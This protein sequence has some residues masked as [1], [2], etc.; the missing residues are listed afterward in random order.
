MTSQISIRKLLK[1]EL[2]Q[3]S[4]MLGLTGLMHLLTGPV[5]F[6]LGTSN[7][8]N[9]S[10]S[11]AV[12][13]YHRFFT[14]SFFIWQLFTMLGCLGVGIFIYRYLFSRR[15]V[16]LY[17]SVPISRSRLFL[18]KYLHGLLIWFLPFAISCGSIFLFYVIRSAGESFFWSGLYAFAKTFLLL[19]LCYFIFYHLFLTAVYLSGNVLNMFTNMAIMGSSVI[20]IGAAIYALADG[21]FDTFC[22]EP[23]TLLE[24]ILLCLSP[25][26]TPF[27]I[28]GFMQ[29]GALNRHVPLLIIS[30]IISL[31]LLDA[32]WILCMKRP[33]ELAER[34]TESP[35]YIMLA[36][37][38][39]TILVGIA[40]ALFFSSISTNDGKLAWGIFGAALG[41][42][43]TFG[44]LNSIYKTT[45]KGFFK[46]PTQL[47]AS[48]AFSILLIVSFQLDWFGYNAYLPQKENLVGMAIYGNQFTDGSTHTE[49]TLNPNSSSLYTT[50]SSIA[51]RVPQ[52]NLLTDIDAC[53]DLLE[54]FVTDAY[55]GIYDGGYS[56]FYAKIKLKSGRT[57]ERRYRIYDEQYAKLKPFIESEDYIAAN[58]KYSTGAFG[59]PYSLTLEL[60]NTSVDIN[61]AKN[62]LAET[63]IQ[64]FMDA[65]YEDFA[66]HFSLEQ[67]ASHMVVFSFSGQ[68]RSNE[69]YNYFS[70]AVPMEY[71]RTLAIV[72]KYYPEHPATIQSAEECT[73]LVLNTGYYDKFIRDGYT[74][75][76]LYE[77]F[78]YPAAN[79]PSQ[80]SLKKQDMTSDTP[81]T[82]VVEIASADGKPMPTAV[83][84]IYAELNITD[85]EILKELFPLLYFGRY[86]DTF[87]L[88]EYIHL[89]YI[90]TL[91]GNSEDCYVKPGTLPKELIEQLYNAREEYTY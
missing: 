86:T 76:A 21:H 37:I 10:E 53:Y 62:D 64:E 85:E 5:V 82:E 3:N 70:L 40:G 46:H 30:I 71:Q 79:G 38:A 41:S 65:Y 7:Y 69:G 36:R 87:D 29:S 83:A 74:I 45:I 19:L 55:T 18:T 77:Y 43:V 48:A 12:T 60:M 28:Y 22:Y 44:L 72:E 25:L 2:R 9:W 57:Y 66:E 35:R 1:Q 89:G 47:L 31:G 61:P 20:G 6:L 58:Y 42:F 27:S 14:D 33:S 75:D 91:K 8:R 24:D 26:T 73:A 17:H 13:R 78:G 59:Y 16:D 32:A 90:R 88:K 80:E 52:T 84:E 54:T 51:G 67:E 34:G 15:M 63:I 81:K 23:S 56:T 4:W 50:S 49:I 11:T 68:Y 39:G